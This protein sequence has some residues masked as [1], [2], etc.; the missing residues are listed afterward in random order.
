MPHS[1][2]LKL[3]SR[4][5]RGGRGLKYGKSVFVVVLASSLPSRGAWI[6]M[7]KDELPEVGGYGRSP[8]GGRGLKCTWF[9]PKNH[10][11]RRSPRGGRGL[12]YGVAS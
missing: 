8:R 3:S 5:P 4:S 12:K 11:R 7:V 1:A 10:C 2:R 9:T 6:E